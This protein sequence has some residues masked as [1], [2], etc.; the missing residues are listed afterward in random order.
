[1]V[2]KAPILGGKEAKTVLNEARLAGVTPP[3][4]EE[5]A[6]GKVLES[7]DKFNAK[8]IQE[9]KKPNKLLLAAIALKLRKAKEEAELKE[10][11]AK[12]PAKLVKPTLEEDPIGRE[13][14]LLKLTGNK[15]DDNKGAKLNLGPLKKAAL[16][17]FAASLKVQV[18]H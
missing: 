13:G 16:K 5:E 3:I 14:K 2:L 7:K 15:E 18:H 9:G 8:L 6:L 17:T 4:R 11:K 1:M 10:G 12:A